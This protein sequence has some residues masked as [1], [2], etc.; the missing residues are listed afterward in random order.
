MGKTRVALVM[1]L[2]TVGGAAASDFAT[3]ADTQ[4]Y[5]IPGTPGYTP[6]GPPSGTTSAIVPPGTPGFS[7]NP[8]FPVGPPPGLKPTP[9]LVTAMPPFVDTSADATRTTAPGATMPM[10][11]GM[12]GPPGPDGCATCG[13]RPHRTCWQALCAYF[14]YRPVALGVKCNECGSCCCYHCYPPL[15]LFMTYQCE[16]RPPTPPCTA[17]CCL[18]P[19]CW[20]PNLNPFHKRECTTCAAHDGI[21]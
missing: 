6:G 11:P 20:L 13:G 9:P 7:P 4:G 19:C 18:R 3:P 12:G 2:L 16:Q 5:A 1:V 8:V 15:Y 21:P 10:A 14:S 17:G